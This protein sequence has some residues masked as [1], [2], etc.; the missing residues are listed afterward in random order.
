MDVQEGRRQKTKGMGGKNGESFS[1]GL[2]KG[3]RVKEEK[4]EKP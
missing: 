4:P 1:L 2:K 3:G